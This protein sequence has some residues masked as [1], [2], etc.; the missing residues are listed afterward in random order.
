MTPNILIVDDDSALLRLLEKELEGYADFFS[1]ITAGDGQGALQV[2][3]DAD[4]SLVICDL[5]MPG[6]DGFELI[7][8]ITKQYP[9][10]PVMAMT[11]HD[12]PKTRDVVLKTGAM[13]YITKPIDGAGLSDR[14][15]K[16]L[17]KRSEGGSL[18][19][20][21]LETYLQL[22]EMEEQTCTLRIISSSGMKSGVLFFRDGRLMEARIGSQRGADAAYEILSW[23]GVALSIE[24]TCPVTEK[25]IEGEL[26][27]ILLDAMRSR[28][29]DESGHSLA[30]EETA[31]DATV[32]SSAADIDTSAENPAEES[33]APKEPPSPA[34]DEPLSPVAFAERKL[35][36]AIGKNSG[37]QDVYSDPIWAGMVY[38]A[39]NAGQVFELGDLNVIYMDRST[40][41]VLVVPGEENVVVVLDKQVP[42][43][44]LI[45]VFV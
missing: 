40:E 26:Q 9:D 7:G 38:H 5:R 15:I 43:E 39:N 22:V 25:H 24:N 36:V 31:G 21:S 19:K 20:V 12:R 8:R 41:Q 30:E 28:D 14:I 11:A 18:R 2:L 34:P 1:V 42:R 10:I 35:F 6:M 13:D 37:I 45:S 27:A 16:I 4:I 3:S 23:P 29:E 44:N 33:A 17:K 32:G